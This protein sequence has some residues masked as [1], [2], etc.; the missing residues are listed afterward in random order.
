MR[1]GNIMIVGVGGQGSLLASKLLGHL[2]LSEPTIVDDPRDQ[3]IMCHVLCVFSFERN[4]YRS[5]YA[6]QLFNIGYQ[7][8]IVIICDIPTSL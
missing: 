4:D 1:S 3:C 2:L 8:L 6:N 5:N 7:A